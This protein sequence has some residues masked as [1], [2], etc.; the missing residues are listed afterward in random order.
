MNCK[1]PQIG[2][3]AKFEVNCGYRMQEVDQIYDSVHTDSEFLHV[4]TEDI[5]E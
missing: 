2:I 5:E 4:P 1:S 3:D